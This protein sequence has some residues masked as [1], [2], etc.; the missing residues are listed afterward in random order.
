MAL[1]A[2]ATLSAV[3]AAVAFSPS[4]EAATS[5]MV[6]AV[7]V[8]GYGSVLANSRRDSLYLLT[9]EVR[10]KLR[11][12]GGCL[13]LWTPVYVKKSKRITVGAGVKGRL[14]RV[15]RGT[16]YQ[17]TFNSYPVYTYVGDHHR[18]AEAHGEGVVFGPKATWY[19][20]RAS[21]KT[22]SATA[23]KHRTSSSGSTTTT[24]SPYGY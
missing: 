2:A 5:P 18:P 13:H 17:V 7:S 22:P 19:L 9:N 6:R 15:R 24:T 8:R 10:A 16:R 1:A 11:C 3:P 12:T 14:G 21:A 23:V 20:I 4:A